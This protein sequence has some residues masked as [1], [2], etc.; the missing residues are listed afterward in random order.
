MSLDPIILAELQRGGPPLWASGRTYRAGQCV[1]SPADWQVYMRTT[2]GAGAADPK[3]DGPNWT[4][5]GAAIEAAVALVSAAVGNV[6]AGVGTVNA[7]V[8]GVSGKVDAVQATVNAI[9]DAKGIK[10]V[11]RGVVTPTEKSGAVVTISG[12]NMSKTVV[13]ADFNSQSVVGGI[14][15]HIGARLMSPTQLNVVGFMDPGGGTV[16]YASV[17]WQAV[18]FY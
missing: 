4:R 15:T 17:A 10:S 8:G 2:T 18:E 5:W 7:A 11:Q 9:N 14:P 6:N 13:F 3:N 16:F 12:V 1:L